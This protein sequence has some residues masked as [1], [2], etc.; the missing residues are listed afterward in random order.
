[1]KYIFII[2]ILILIIYY[3][4]LFDFS[5]DNVITYKDSKKFNLNQVVDYMYLKKIKKK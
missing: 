4:F 1:M 3:Y 5:P 2:A